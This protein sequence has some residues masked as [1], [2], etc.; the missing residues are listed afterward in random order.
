MGCSNI[1]RNIFGPENAGPAKPCVVIIG[2]PDS[3]TTTQSKKI[4]DKYEY[5]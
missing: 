3:G 4:V 2:A 5:M 1:K